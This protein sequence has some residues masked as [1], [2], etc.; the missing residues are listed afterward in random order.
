MPVWI[1][2]P[3]R[4]RPWRIVRLGVAVAILSLLAVTLYM[5]LSEPPTRT[6]HPPRQAGVMGE[7]SPAVTAPDER[8][9]NI[10]PLLVVMRDMSSGVT[11]REGRSRDT[12]ELLVDP[13]PDEPGESRN[14]E[15][16][17]R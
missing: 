3:E 14:A 16:R 13:F 11:V 12:P 6:Q 17:R 7:E 8:A 2:R 10:R 1:G 4:P 9:R 15:E 5:T